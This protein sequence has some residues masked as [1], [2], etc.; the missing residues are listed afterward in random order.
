MSPA[1]TVQPV[2]Y[3]IF[4]A[5][6]AFTALHLWRSLRQRFSHRSANAHAKSFAF[7]VHGIDQVESTSA[8]RRPRRLW[9]WEALPPIEMEIARLVIQGKYDAEIARDLNISVG[10]VETHL[11]HM[12]EKLKV[13]SRVELARTIR[14]LV[15]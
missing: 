7:M 1:E 8:D 4:G 15:D 2:F 14:D 6:I 3:F 12:Y 11:D 13:R 10:T 9:H 5:F